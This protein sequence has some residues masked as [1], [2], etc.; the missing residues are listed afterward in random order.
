MRVLFWGTSAFAVPSLQA[1]LGEGFETVAVVTQPDRPTGRSRS[2]LTPPPIKQCALIERLPIL[3]PERPRGDDF[4][5]AVR[6][7]EPDISVVVSYGH[8]L[9][10][11]VIDLPTRGTINVHASLLPALR[12]AAPI[13]AAIRDGLTETGVSIMR[14][15]PA[16]DA[17]PVVLQ[18]RTP[19]ADDETYGEL[20]LRL[21]EL[22]A[23]ALVEALT[24]LELDRA[25]E[26]PQE[27]NGATYATKIDRADARVSWHSP[28]AN[29]ARCIRAYDP[30]PG[31]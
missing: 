2:T 18:A 11:Q 10:K 16:L 1:C 13:Q 15:V 22:G 19:I 31:A 28:A 3:Q 24:L 9:S 30:K 12:G 20:E 14:M 5:A 26:T 8:I 29:V 23:L 21:S 17:G 7:L 6:A 25:T 27:E 4:L